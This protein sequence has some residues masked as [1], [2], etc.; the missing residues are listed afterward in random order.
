VRPQSSDSLSTL[1]LIS[2]FWEMTA[3]KGR[4]FHEVTTAQKAQRVVDSRKLLTVLGIY[5]ANGLVN[6]IISD[7]SWYYWSYHHSSQGSASRYLV[8]IRP[9]MKTDSKKPIPLSC[10]MIGI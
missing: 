2:N 3:K 10:S 4:D 1:M 5:A 7:E 9:P 8:P 6:I